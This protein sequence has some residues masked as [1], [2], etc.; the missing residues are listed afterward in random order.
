M[1][2]LAALSRPW[3]TGYDHASLVTAVHDQGKPTIASITG[4]TTLSYP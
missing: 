1:I 4:Q 3:E 2:L